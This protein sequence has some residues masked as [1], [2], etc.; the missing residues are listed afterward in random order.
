M[1]G[2]ESATFV[3]SKEDWTPEE[4]SRA[5]RTT[6]TVGWNAENDASALEIS[7]R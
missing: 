5:E 2:R 1:D 7:M 4:W 3:A 6:F